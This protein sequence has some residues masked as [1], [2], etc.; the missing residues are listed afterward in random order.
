M[1]LFTVTLP[2][3]M[4]HEAANF[5][6]MLEDC[7][8]KDL[9]IE[10]AEEPNGQLIQFTLLSEINGSRINCMGLLPNFR[11]SE[12]S[13]VV[14]RAASKAIAEFIISHMETQILATIIRRKYRNS[15]SAEAH[16]IEKYCHE[17]LHGKEWDG[18]GTKFLDADR[19]RRKTK[20]ADEIKSFLQENSR[21]DLTGLTTF[22]LRLYR[23]ELTEIVEYAL[24]EYVL[25]KQYQEF[26]SLLKYFVGL[27]DSK[28]PIVHLVHKGNHEFV[29]YNDKFQLFEPKPHSDRL[30]AEMLETE[31]NIEDMVISSLIAVS[32]KHIMIHTRQPDMQVI[33]TIETIFD[34]RVSVCMQCSACNPCFEAFNNGVQP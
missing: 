24:D 4:E 3:S 34:N 2:Q 31:M 23:K 27:Q 30:V 13:P 9:H 7:V 25:D 33:R 19:Q 18:L 20:V 12:H 8:C 10:A 15:Y 26:I 28:V 22:R 16:L 1:E 21:L 17:L 11:L 29:M 32:P 5:V 14:Y 6:K